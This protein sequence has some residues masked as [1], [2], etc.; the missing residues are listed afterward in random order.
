MSHFPTSGFLSLAFRFRSG[1][2]RLSTAIKRAV[3]VSLYAVEDAE[4]TVVQ[5]LPLSTRWSQPP[6]VLVRG[7][8]DHLGEVTPAT[9]LASG[10]LA[11]LPL[12]STVT[13]NRRASAVTAELVE[14][15]VLA[16]L[17]YHQSGPTRACS[18]SWSHPGSSLF[19]PSAVALARKRTWGSD[20]QAAQEIP[21]L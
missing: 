16:I 12:R 18:G 5:S 4:P 15:A 9:L 10:G 7:E 21:A 13:T 2:P 17:L 20:C 1:S 6:L 19:P 8:S 11:V 14:R 3:C